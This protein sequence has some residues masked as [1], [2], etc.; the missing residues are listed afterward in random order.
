MEALQ[1]AHDDVKAHVRVLRV[2]FHRNNRDDDMQGLFSCVQSLDI[3]L[4]R[5]V[6]DAM[7]RHGTEEY[8]E[9]PYDH[10]IH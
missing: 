9:D 5:Q 4:Y 6:I 2:I 7:N 10:Y 1:L 3:D 8:M